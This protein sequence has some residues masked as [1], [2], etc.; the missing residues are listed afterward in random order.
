MDPKLFDRL[1]TMPHAKA[2]AIAIYGESVAAYR[3]GILAEK[4]LPEEHRKIFNEMRDEERGHQR[5]LEALA[6]SHFPDGDFVLSAEDKDMVIVGAR[7]L[8]V[9][10][11]ESFLNA[12][13]FLHDTEKRTGDFYNTLHQ[14]MPEG[15]LGTFL[16]QMAAE[17]YE[18]GDS[19]LKIDPPPPT[20]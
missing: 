16:Q 2:I 3:Y 11:R 17:C 12:M 10:D 5:A 19:L 7:M 13:R 14:M 4:A 15:K 1:R 6:Q 18:H 20:S 9:T 8:E